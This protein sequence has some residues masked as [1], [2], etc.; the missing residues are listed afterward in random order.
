MT[1][2][3]ATRIVLADETETQPNVF[4][5][6]DS[7]TLYIPTIPA[8]RYKLARTDAA[9]V[10]AFIRQPD[11]A[12][13]YR[14]VDRN[15]RGWL[16]CNPQPSTYPELDG[17]APETYA[18]LAADRGPLRPVLAMTRV[19]CDRLHRA[20]AEAE[21]TAA[22]TLISALGVL[23]DECRERDGHTGRLVAGRPGSWESEL[24]PR[25]GGHFARRISADRVDTQ[26]LAVV[27]EVV[28]G[29]I[30][31]DDRYTEVAESLAE[32]F[33]MVVDGRGGWE[34]VADR[35]I[36]TGP[37]AEQVRNYL[38]SGSGWYH[39]GAN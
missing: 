13:P 23:A 39:P 29:W 24:L 38:T 21:I 17:P 6:G 8:G 7:R 15:Q 2:T 35:R 1:E 14:V 16:T 36:R 33:G 11:P 31:R 5:S 20:L 4:I 3:P 18:Q 32:M 22:A 10:W 34:R 19:D 37:D 9:G 30:F 26:A 12:T 27:T 28:R 25:L